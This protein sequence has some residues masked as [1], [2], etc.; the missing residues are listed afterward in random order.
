L[1]EYLKRLVVSA[2]LAIVIV[3]GLAFSV[4][5]APSLIS[6]TQTPEVTPTAHPSPPPPKLDMRADFASVEG[7]NITW[8]ESQGSVYRVL[9][10]P[11]GKSGSV[12][13]RLI[14]TGHEDY[15]VSLEVVLAAENLRFE[16]V[17]YT[18]SPSTL[19]LKAGTGVNSILNIEAES[20]AP[21]ALYTLC[22]DAHV[23]GYLSMPSVPLDLVIYPY[24]PS[25]AFRIYAPPPGMPTPTPTEA[26]IPK[27]AVKPGE[28]IYIMFDIDKGTDDPAVQ[29][30][31]NLTHD[32]GPLPSAIVG[33]FNPLEV[34]TSPK[35]GNVT[36]LTLTTA[37]DLPEGVYKMIVTIS[38]D[39]YTTERAFYLTVAS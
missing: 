27:I 17:K 37:T 26:P 36:M 29:V 24:T 39:S 14:S 10:L 34:I 2:V 4:L 6:P 8:M 35:Y 20:K 16:G 1:S 3:I 30:K 11:P 18:L 21:T 12:A 28:T 25:Y 23:Q 5:L 13:I 9:V 38:V 19:N 7:F 15:E 31:L 33:E 32:P 22:V